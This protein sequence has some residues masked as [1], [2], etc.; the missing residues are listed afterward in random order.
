MKSASA[1]LISLLNTSSVFYPADLY[2]F[3]LISGTVVR[4]TSH[5]I[6]IQVGVL[7]DLK[8]SLARLCRIL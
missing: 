6:N 2:T 4:Y 1:S 8:D 7:C 5:D 3:T